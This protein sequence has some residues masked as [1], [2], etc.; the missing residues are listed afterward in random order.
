MS[1]VVQGR[2]IVALRQASLTAG[3]LAGIVW[4][5][6]HAAAQTASSSSPGTYSL[7][8]LALFPDQLQTLQQWDGQNRNRSP[9]KKPVPVTPT[10]ECPPN[11]FSPGKICYYK[12]GPSIL[13]KDQVEAVQQWDSQNRNL[14]K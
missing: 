5:T 7:G 9:K 6:S 8:T 11:N 2:M 13:Y 10:P 14:V 1:S 12:V 3:A 4:L